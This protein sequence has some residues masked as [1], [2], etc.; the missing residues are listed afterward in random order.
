MI[1][2]DTMDEE[3]K[4][5]NTRA[6]KEILNGLPNSMKANF[7]K[8]L[9]TKVIWDKIHDLHSEVAL[10]MIS[11]QEDDGKQ[12]RSLESIKESEDKRDE[13]KAKEDL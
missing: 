12:E 5:Y 11:S 9:S 10:T 7:E 4:E 1:T 8:C 6:M 2:N 3:Y 13:N